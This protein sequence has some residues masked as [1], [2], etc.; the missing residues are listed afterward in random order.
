MATAFHDTLFAYILRLAF[1][2]RA[3]PYPDEKVLPTIWQEKLT[4]Q[5][6]PRDSILLKPDGAASPDATSI[7]SGATAMTSTPGGVDPEKGQD[8]LLVDWYGP[9]DPDVSCWCG[10]F[11]RS[12]LQR[13]TESTELVECEEIMGHVS[14]V[15]S[16]DR[17][18]RWVWH[19]YRRDPLYHF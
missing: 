10:T 2:S 1:G 6:S 5:V 8:P 3:F 14:D 19:L 4:S 18:L 15:S 9:T 12:Y 13:T 16:D 7:L 17:C 11:A